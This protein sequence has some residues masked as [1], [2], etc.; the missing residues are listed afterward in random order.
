M[1]GTMRLLVLGGTWFLGRRLI[2]D[3]LARGWEVS[4]FSRGQSGSPPRGAAHVRGDR[5]SRDDLKRLA[6]IGPWDTTIDTSAFEP[7]D[8][9][10]VLGALDQQA[11]RYVLISTVSAYRDWPNEPVDERSPLWPSH[12]EYTESSPELADMPV[13]LRYGTLKAGCELAATAASPD[14]L[15]LRPGVILGPGEYIGR[16]MKLLERA[17]RGGRWL[18]PEPRRQS[19]QPVD[20]RDVSSFILKAIEASLGGAYNLAAPPG[21]ATYEDLISSCI[22]LTGNKTT[23]VWVDPKRLDTHG[24]K[25][26][27]EIPLWRTQPGTWAVDAGRAA[28]AGFSCRP[29][30]ETIADFQ[31]AMEREPIID[32]PR[33]SAHGMDPTKEAELLTDWDN[34]SVRVTIDSN[35]KREGSTHDR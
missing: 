20:V 8:V 2:M 4:A 23:P 31:T 5:G 21:F 26:W 33:Q 25:Q 6:K 34:D 1:I 35:P 29:L 32:H 15:L 7:A 17:T 16:G 28:A 10:R 30:L 14:A 24:V 18:L 12:S 27:T 3:A 22:K 11:G 9:A 19:I 13:P